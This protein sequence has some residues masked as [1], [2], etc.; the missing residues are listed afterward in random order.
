[1]DSH[2]TE[3]VDPD[4]PVV[5]LAILAPGT[6]VASRYEIERLLGTGGFARVYAAFDRE[7]GQRIAIKILRSE[8]MNPASLT[9]MRREVT[10]ARELARP[11]LVRVYDL[12]QDGEFTFLT[13]E[14]V[15]GE[16]LRDM[17]RRG[18]M[19]VEEVVRIGEPILD[20]LGALHDAGVVHRDLKPANI[21]LTPDGG[22]KL[23]DFGLARRWDGGEKV[24]R[25][26]A[27]VGTLEYVAPEQA[28]GKQLD[29]RADLYAFGVLLFEL[30]TTKLPLEA[31][32][33]LGT[34]MAHI[35][36]NAPDVRTLRPD[37]PPWLAELIQRLMEKNPDGRPQSAAEALARLRAR[38]R[39]L[40]WRWKRSR[41]R[42]AT[43]ALVA[44]TLAAC[45]FV[46][47]QRHWS[48]FDHLEG[49]SERRLT[50]IDRAGRVLWKD[51]TL[52]PGFSAIALKPDGKRTVVVGVPLKNSG[53]MPIEEI[54]RMRLYSAATGEV[55]KQFVL[56]DAASRFPLDPTFIVAGISAI[57]PDHDGREDALLTYAHTPYWPSYS[58]YVDPR[59]GKSAPILIASGHHRL[60]GLADLDG[61]GA[62]ELLFSGPN[63][64]MGWFTGIAAV[65]LVRPS[66]PVATPL[67]WN[68]AGTPD[69]DYARAS[70]HSL[71]WYSLQPRMSVYSCHLEDA[72]S[73]RRILR[74]G[75][76]SD[77]TFEL[78]YDG[79]LAGSRSALG[80]EA[81]VAA[82]QAA[83]DELRNALRT[84]TMGAL[85]RAI[86]L[87]KEAH[88][89][90]VAANDVPLAEWIS[91]NEAILL[92]RAGRAGEAQSL[93]EALAVSSDAPSE[94]CWQAAI[95][96][97]QQGDLD[98]AA[99]FHRRGL[100]EGTKGVWRG[101][102]ASDHL[103]SLL[104]VL[105]QRERW[106]EARADLARYEAT[107]P[108]NL[109][110]MQRVRAYIDWRS[111]VPNGTPLTI[112][113]SRPELFN[114]CVFEA[115]WAQGVPDAGAFLREMNDFRKLKPAPA[116]LYE[117]LEAE[118]LAASG[119]TSEAKALAAKALA[120]TIAASKDES[121]ARA[122]L[123]LV[124]RRSEAI[125]RRPS[126]H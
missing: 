55:T 3:T 111:G 54:H 72:N 89:R 74:F 117:S 15:E 122:H 95:V 40:R 20:A 11:T 75:C 110:N 76:G 26:E 100:E 22:V 109:G 39:D 62:D 32:T 45:G 7:L 16:T 24:T 114:Y 124:Q 126:E 84:G 99:R 38:R 64:R 61:D 68:E 120:E 31:A 53:R 52:A 78:G 103:E 121:I 81:R 50:A 28:L 65:K 88:A 30:L 97:E 101:R 47:W 86:S 71:V 79:F 90:A 119:R 17:I 115:R 93:F 77:G 102:I 36:T 98:R 43:Y 37:A 123:R 19:T 6:L 85:D 118:V 92:A 12:G 83:Y 105:A 70:S 87:A 69:A 9:R 8:R 96:F 57:D 60:A 41:A 46:A 125:A 51:D 13:M 106:D 104:L 5:D 113:V 23:G 116:Y 63:N 80:P 33:N 94:I 58:V 18:A 29:G 4:D 49:D 1:M 21:L 73:A 25:T 44:V 2:Q 10:I 67:L 34:V 107:Y 56:A 108:E 48:A 91:T 35:I 27:L 112:N 66:A 14:L 59:S 42:V 82:R